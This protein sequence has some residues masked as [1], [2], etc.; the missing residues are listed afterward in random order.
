MRHRYL[1]SLLTSLI[2][3][4]GVSLADSSPFNAGINPP[5]L[6]AAEKEDLKQF[7]DYTKEALDRAQRDADGKTDDQALVI[8]DNIVRS[9]VVASA[10]SQPQRELLIRMILNQALEL[11]ESVLP[12]AIPTGLR[13]AIYKSS[14]ELALQYAPKERFA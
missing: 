6:T 11:D 8:Y 9:V 4:P 13:V 10:A 14:I 2:M 1:I 7:I 3:L 12:E 5:A